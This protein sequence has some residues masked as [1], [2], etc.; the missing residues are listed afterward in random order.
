MSPVDWKLYPSNWRTEIV[1]AV[2][3]RSGGK[4]EW[5]GVQN[6]SVGYRAEPTKQFVFLG[7]RRNWKQARRLKRHLESKLH[8]QNVIVIVLSVMHLDHDTSRNDMDNLKDACQRCHSLYDEELH[9]KN[10]VKNKAHKEAVEYFEKLNAPRS[11]PPQPS[12]FDLDKHTEKDM[13]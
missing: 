11:N 10:R 13:P 2:R 8:Y 9:K 7:W 4:C 12:L 6:L 5:C 3:E 1:P